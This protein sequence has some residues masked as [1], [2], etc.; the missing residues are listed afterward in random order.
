MLYTWASGRPINAHANVASRSRC[1]LSRVLRAACMR[2]AASLEISLF[3]LNELWLS[4]T[5][6]VQSDFF[7]FHDLKKAQKLCFLRNAIARAHGLRKSATRRDSVPPD[8]AEVPC[9]QSCA[10]KWVPE[11]GC[12]RGAVA[13]GPGVYLSRS[14]SACLAAPVSGGNASLE[15]L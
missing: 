4:P 1:M 5:P 14:A 6:F 3:F 9:T 10:K 13:D 2:H 11:A 7:V 12:S 15:Y 8:G